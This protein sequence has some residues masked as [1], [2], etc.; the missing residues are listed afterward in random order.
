[1]N[2]YIPTTK[3]YDAFHATLLTSKSPIVK[4]SWLDFFDPS[5]NDFVPLVSK[6]DFG[7]KYQDLT[8]IGLNLR[9]KTPFVFRGLGSD[10]VFKSVEEFTSIKLHTWIPALEAE[11]LHYTG[12]PHLPY[13]FVVKWPLKEPMPLDIFVH[14]LDLAI[15]GHGD[16]QS[17][18][19]HV[20]KRSDS[21]EDDSEYCGKKIKV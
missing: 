17:V 13:K 5:T 11:S 12:Y 7:K 20:S 3:D 19:K 6:S 4:K 15:I 21:K 16:Y 2:K 10:L 8:F 18:W 14:H 1:M 9:K